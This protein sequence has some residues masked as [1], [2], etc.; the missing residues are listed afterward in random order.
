MLKF[1]ICPA[2]FWCRWARLRDIFGVTE[3][4]P[5]TSSMSLD[6]VTR[7]ICCR[8]T[9]RNFEYLRENK[10][11][12]NNILVRE[13]VVQEELFDEKTRG[14]ISRVSVPLKIVNQ[15]LRKQP[16]FLWERYFRDNNIIARGQTF[17]WQCDI[18]EYRKAQ[19]DGYRS[20]QRL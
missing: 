2:T 16:I 20:R 5:T 14:R 19:K 17:L 8:G 15:Q 3:P 18:E 12:S 9:R 1:F 11:E 6:K 4:C 10:I 7:Y 13:S